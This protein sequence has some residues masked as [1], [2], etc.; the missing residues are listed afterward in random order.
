MTHGKAQTLPHTHLPG[1]PCQPCSGPGLRKGG[2]ET[3]PL[4]SPAG[5]LEPAFGPPP[6]LQKEEMEQHRSCPVPGL[7]P[8]S[9]PTPS[10][11]SPGAWMAQRCQHHRGGDALPTR[12]TH[13][14]GEQRAGP[15]WEQAG[16]ASSQRGWGGPGSPQGRRH[17][18]K[19][20]RAPD[21]C[22]AAQAWS[23]SSSHAPACCLP[24]LASNLCQSPSF[25]DDGK[26]P[27]P[28]PTLV[29]WAM[30]PA[31]PPLLSLLQT[32]ED[33]LG[34]SFQTLEAEAGI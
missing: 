1:I 15:L 34:H 3:P 7:P 27:C 2:E 4:K 29:S 23:R 26:Q 12:A 31:H 20:G 30:P 28:P 16:P 33:L 13:R 19:P 17:S 14:P 18:L 10:G 32:P 21:G 9:C 24:C 6:C 11:A 25:W 22:P 8:P 5:H